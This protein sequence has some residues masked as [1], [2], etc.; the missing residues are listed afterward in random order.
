MSER[1]SV[2]VEMY[3]AQF[4][5]NEYVVMG[6]VRD[7][8]SILRKIDEVHRD[9]Y[10]VDMYVDVY[11]RERPE[12]Q[13]SYAVMGCMDPVELKQFVL[14]V[15]PLCEWYLLANLREADT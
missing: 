15:W 7:F 5:G 2:T 1:F 3:S 14:R 6:D 11:D 8:A 9:R 12:F 4:E 13:E 10:M